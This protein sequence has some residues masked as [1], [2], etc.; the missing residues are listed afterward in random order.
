MSQ[1]GGEIQ[2]GN[3]RFITHVHT[4]GFDPV[5]NDS[6]IDLVVLVD[7]GGD[8]QAAQLIL[9]DLKARLIGKEV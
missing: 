3:A 6:H 4:D 2:I 5:R 7:D 8:P 9:A 1:W